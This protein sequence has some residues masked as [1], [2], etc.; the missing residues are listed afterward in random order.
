[1]LKELFVGIMFAV[2]AAPAAAQLFG[3][4]ELLEPEKAFRISARALDE[5]NVEV[6]FKIADGYYMYRD[7]F[8]FATE[9][10]KPLAEVE[11]PRGKIKEDQF[12]GKTETFRH[13]VRMRVPVSPDDTAAG[14]VKLKVTSQGCSDK[15]VCYTPLEQ[16]VRVSL[17]NAGAAPRKSVSPLASVQVPWLLLA[18]SLA[19]G[20]A[21]GWVS[22]GAPLVRDATAQ[23]VRGPVFLWA[24]A[25][26]ATGALFGWLGSLL[27]GRAE[28]PFVAAPLALAYVATAAFWL[29]WS[30]HAG[31]FNWPIRAARDVALLAAVLLFAVYLGGP[32]IGAAAMLGAGL[33][34]GLFPKARTEA[35][36][37]LALQAAALA[38]LAAAAWVAAP[39][40]PD[41]LRMLAWAAWMIATATMLRAI[42][43]L[44]EGAAWPHRVL[45]AFGLVTLVW[46]VAVLIGAA[47]GARDPLRPFEGLSIAG[48]RIAEAAP[49]RFER[50]ATLGELEARI[51]SAGRPV[52]LDFYADWCISC[53]EMERFT[54]SDPQVAARMQR[55]LLLQVDVT[56]N[57]AEDQA[58]LKRFRLFGPP[59]II[60]FDA[61]GLEIQEL[62]VV[63]Y[64]PA[65][66][67][68]RVLD[69]ALKGS[70]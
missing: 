46:G 11:I 27:P 15:G 29:R 54:F 8:S 21:L 64:Q 66:R 42:D 4:P 56:R 3:Q 44:P 37:E 53:K 50:V 14:I 31:E 51:A 36:H 67:F 28:N 18:A 19:G 57:S 32:W 13:L 2:T 41:E 52:M 68:A 30:G 7:R 58:I 55:M 12:F 39:V 22:A 38:M 69:A 17:P 5:R 65:A 70:S 20:L 63:G 9:A 33:G 49:V 45:K 6:E 25:L 61:T 16:T 43:P 24:A 47:S 23:L 34:C 1:M 10:G 35:R 40:L 59:G 60:F 26:A 48:K 62:R